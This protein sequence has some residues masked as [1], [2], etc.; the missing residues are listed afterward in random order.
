VELFVKVREEAECFAQSAAGVALFHVEHEDAE[1]LVG[2]ARSAA[3]GGASGS[4]QRSSPQP[5]PAVASAQRTR[6]RRDCDHRAG[7]LVTAQHALTVVLA[8]SPPRP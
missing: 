3:R 7:S 1:L 8:G 5:R 2:G 6:T 4:P